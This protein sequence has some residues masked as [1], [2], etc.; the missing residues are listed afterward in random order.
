[1]DLDKLVEWAEKWQ[2]QFNVRKCKV[3][4]VGQK[5]PRFSN[6][7]SNNGLQVVETEKDLGVMISSDL[8][9]SH[10]QPH[11]NVFMLIR[12]LLGSWV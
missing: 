10:S 5:N 9:C 6:S 11:S 1:V 4:Y 3:M 12:R 8:K 2:M 7:M